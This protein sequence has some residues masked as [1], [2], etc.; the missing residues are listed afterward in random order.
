M[1]SCRSNNIPPFIVMEILERALDLEREGRS[2]IHME[3]GEP[4]FDTPACVKEA[5]VRAML[6]GN[7]HYTSSLGLSELREAVSQ[8][9]RD[10]YGVDVGAERVI[11][12]SGTSPALLLIYA[13]L[14]DPDDEIILSDPGYACYPNMVEFVDGKPV[15]V[16]V[17]EEDGFS[18]RHAD[19]AASIGPRTKGIM[20]NSPS[21]PTGNLLDLETMQ[22]IA[23]LGRQGLYV[24]SDEIYHGLVYQGREHSILEFTDHAFVVNGFSKLY[25]MTGWRL[26]YLIA[27]SHFI[28][29]IQKMQ[30][31][32]F[33]SAN[34]F[35]QHAGIAALTLAQPEVAEMVRLYDERRRYLFASLKELGFSISV[36]PEGAFYIMAGAR[37]FSQDSYAFALELLEEAG[38]AVT[39]G[40]DF[41]PGGEGYI[42]F[43]YTTSLENIKEGIRRLSHH[44]EERKPEPTGKAGGAR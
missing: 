44:L 26:G 12:T 25:A 28:R 42:R 11:V 6:E 24:V 13:A 38:V 29:P 9:Y 39:P 34:A 36:E 41:G 33:I 7:T 18:Y 43:S 16:R 23:G 15:C 35:V 22:D 5:A 20:I 37:K 17:F 19:I 10:R 40:I 1:I 8:H 27:P 14:L 31:N 30:Q 4:D 2:I 3:V 32:L 21:N